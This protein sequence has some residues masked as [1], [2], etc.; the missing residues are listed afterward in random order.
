MALEQLA[1][2]LSNIYPILYAIAIIIATW[3]FTR[4]VDAIAKRALSM[5]PQMVLTQV[6][7]GLS[8]FIWFVGILIAIEQLGLRAEVLIAILVLVGVAIIIALRDVLSNI[9][10]K[11]FSDIYVP[12]KLGDRINI[13][14]YSGTVIEINPIVTVILMDDGKIASIPNRLFT[15][16]AMV[17]ETSETWREI[18]IPVSVEKGL[19]IAEVEAEILRRVN[20]LRHRLDDRFPPRIFTRR[21]GGDTQL[22]IIV[23]IKDPM[24]RDAIYNEI[25]RKV[26]EA[27]EELR[28]RARK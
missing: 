4:V 9:A 2:L 14:G 28:S 5:L 24:D 12:Y 17:N 11:Y 25:N 10:S 18:A 6:R 20:K 1:S 3:V 13:A 16:E 19:D 15:T 23:K 22:L 7:K 26:I 8:V 27:I 21:V